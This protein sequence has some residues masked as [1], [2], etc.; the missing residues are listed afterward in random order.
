MALMTL[1]D[2]AKYMGMTT[3][4]AFNLRVSGRIAGMIEVKRRF[5]LVDT[6]KAKILPPANKPRR[7]DGP[8][9]GRSKP[10]RGEPGFK[11]KH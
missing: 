3:R 5:Y 1:T 10:M 7:L 2:W 4:H 6:E 11:P 9:I 8:V